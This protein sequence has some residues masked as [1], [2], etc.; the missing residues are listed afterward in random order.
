[1]SCPTCSH[2]MTPMGCK[3]TDKT[4]YWCPRCGTIK[5]CEEQEAVTPA[6]VERCREFEKTTTRV[7]SV[8]ED[9]LSY[10]WNHLGIAESINP[11]ENRPPEGGT[12]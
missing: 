1:M 8:D 6:L 5:P 7:G 4:F 9:Q 2:T 11:P 10:Q 12:T 3:V